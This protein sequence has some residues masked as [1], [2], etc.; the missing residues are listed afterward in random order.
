MASSPTFHCSSM[1]LVTIHS[2]TR[3]VSSPFPVRGERRGRD[4]LRSLPRVPPL[5]TSQHSPTN[6]HKVINILSR[7]SFFLVNLFTPIQWCIF[8]FSSD[9]LAHRFKPVFSRNRFAS[10]LSNGMKTSPR[11]GLC[12]A[13]LV[14]KQ[15]YGRENKRAGGN[16]GQTYSLG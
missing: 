2:K 6:L 13:R 15:Q 14:K 1:R 8:F 10:L 12:D 7:A 16:G 11:P 9:R 4:A 5:P 3:R